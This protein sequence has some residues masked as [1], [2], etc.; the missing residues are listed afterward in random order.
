M[1]E[2]TAIVAAV[3]MF[4]TLEPRS[5]EAVA[6]LARIITVP[7]ATVLVREGETPESFYVIVSGT[8]RIERD[9][10]FVRSMSNGGFLGEV[11]LIE[12]GQR[13]ATATCTTSCQ[14]LE[15]GSFEFGRVMATFPDVRARVE[16]AVARRP[17]SATP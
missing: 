11:A 16:A 2:K 12:G 7:S 15:F 6:T 10:R 9:G 13:T 5:L 14:L 1:D 17:H 4:A 3:P 8:V